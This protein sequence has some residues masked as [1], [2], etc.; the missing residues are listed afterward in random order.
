MVLTG[1]DGHRLALWE[2]LLISLRD[3]PA[4][5]RDLAARLVVPQSSV[6][7]NLCRYPDLFHHADTARPGRWWGLSN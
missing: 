6:R 1:E 2:R 4:R 3:G 5:P 7:T